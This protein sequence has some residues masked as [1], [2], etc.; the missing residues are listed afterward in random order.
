MLSKSEL[1][2]ACETAEM[3]PAASELVQILR[4]ML[5]T[6]SPE[7]CP[8]DAREDWLSLNLMIQ[9]R[10]AA[11]TSPAWLTRLRNWLSGLTAPAPSYALASARA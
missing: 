11:V 5:P 3:A 7:E 9:P 2:E 1:R 4:E 8:A 6:L 10:P